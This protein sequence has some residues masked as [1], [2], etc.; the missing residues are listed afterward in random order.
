LELT[1]RWLIVPGFSGAQ[2]RETM[3]TDRQA[4]TS[5][6]GREREHLSQQQKPH[7]M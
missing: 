5:R 2:Y 7:I 4:G 6:E 1:E 3:Q